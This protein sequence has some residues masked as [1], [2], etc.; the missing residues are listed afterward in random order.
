M[1]EFLK[2]LALAAIPGAG[3]FVRVLAGEVSRVGG[4]GLSYAL[5]AAAGV[6]LGVVGVEILPRALEVSQPWL[7]V[8]AFAIGSAAAVAID[9]VLHGLVGEQ[10]GP[11][12]VWTATA[13]DLFSDGLLIGAGSTLDFRRGL[14]LAIAQVPADLPEGFS[15]S[16]SFQAAGIGRGRRLLYALAF[17]VPLA[18]GAAMGFF[19]VRGQSDL[20]KHGLLSFAGG[21]LATLAIDEVLGEAHESD[22]EHSSLQTLTMTAGFAFFALLS[23]YFELRVG[24]V[25]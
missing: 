2:V 7:I 16:A 14:L 9:R 25:C 22:E 23:I 6:M 24:L 12:G 3:N 5:H 11:W 10:A 17:F 15:T 8:V 13:V 19:L 21:L 20:L 1:T 18:A 4:R